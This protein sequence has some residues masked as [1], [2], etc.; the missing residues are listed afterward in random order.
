MFRIAVAR[1]LCA[2]MGLL[3]KGPDD[4]VAR[5]S[6]AVAAAIWNN[7][8]L[9]VSRVFT[10]QDARLCDRLIQSMA[11]HVPGL[12]SAETASASALNQAIEGLD[13]S[14]SEIKPYHL[15][16]A[17]TSA[18]RQH[19]ADGSALRVAVAGQQA[20]PDLQQLTSDMDLPG[21]LD[22]MLEYSFSTTDHGYVTIDR[23]HTPHNGVSTATFT[24]S[25]FK[26]GRQKH[27]FTIKIA[28]SHD[29]QHNMTPSNFED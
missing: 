10:S 29:G 3:A 16:A 4:E 27:N 19:Q 6:S 25:D 11:A 20:A 12:N 17:M 1:S 28:H 24:I 5:V 23:N 13:G 2:A 9:L 15:V 14:D 21:D 22:A 26:V 18:F 8:P 7:H